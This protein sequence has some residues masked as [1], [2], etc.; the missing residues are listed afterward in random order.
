MSKQKGNSQSLGLSVDDEVGEVPNVNVSQSEIPVVDLPMNVVPQGSQFRP[1]CTVHN[2]YMIPARTQGGTTHYACK[3]PGCDCKQKV[4]RAKTAIPS[5]PMECSR[6]TCRSPQQYLQVD[7]NFLGQ[8]KL[9]MKCPQCGHTVEVQ[10]PAMA[11][12][13]RQVEADNDLSAR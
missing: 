4:A 5:D 3:V 13:S 2:C 7:M 8:A 10:R 11:T 12:A 1:H 9:R 6:I